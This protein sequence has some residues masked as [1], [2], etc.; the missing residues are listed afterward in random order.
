MINHHFP[1]P[2]P[3]VNHTPHH[4]IIYIYVHINQ[5]FP[6]ELTDKNPHPLPTPALPRPPSLSPSVDLSF[7]GRT[8]G[9]G[10]SSAKGVGSCGDW[11][12]GIKAWW[13]AGARVM[14]Q[15]GPIGRWEKHRK[16]HR[17]MLIEV[18]EMAISWD[19]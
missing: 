12:A 1:Y 11:A 7:L 16:N 17:K 9:R 2:H 18:R 5:Q 15:G 8:A 3:F 4:H 13:K 10:F 14:R 6:F 19:L